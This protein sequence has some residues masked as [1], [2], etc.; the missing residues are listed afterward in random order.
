MLTVKTF[1][2]KHIYLRCMQTSNLNCRSIHTRR[3]VYTHAEKRTHRWTNTPD[4]KHCTSRSWRDWVCPGVKGWPPLGCNTLW[5]CR[6]ESPWLLWL[7]LG[8]L[9]YPVRRVGC[10]LHVH[11]STSLWFLTERQIGST[12]PSHDQN[13]RM[14]V[15]VEVWQTLF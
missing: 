2:L 8:T 5:M 4:R 9:T 6:A 7:S 13:D 11:A 3:E 10:L 14:W 12:K 15:A 1:R